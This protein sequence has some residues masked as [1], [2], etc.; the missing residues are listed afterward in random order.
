MK[1][2]A[3]CLIPKTSAEDLR[4]SLQ[5]QTQ[6]LDRISRSSAESL[7]A[8]LRL[9]DVRPDIWN[10]DI[11]QD[12]VISHGKEKDIA[13]WSKDMTC[14]IYFLYDQLFFSYASAQLFQNILICYFEELLSRSVLKKKHNN[15]SFQKIHKKTPVVESFCSEV[16]G[17]NPVGLLKFDSDTGVFL[18]VFRTSANSCSALPVIKLL[19]STKSKLS[20][21]FSLTFRTT[22]FSFCSFLLFYHKELDFLCKYFLFYESYS[23]HFQ[24][25]I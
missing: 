24:R 3:G 5:I 25:F 16:T 13:S 14:L 18:W 4:T 6:T 23:F 12:V 15:E 1:L 17:L 20:A 7:N 21:V 9:L 11:R 10:S 22:I 2:S 8:R 19:F